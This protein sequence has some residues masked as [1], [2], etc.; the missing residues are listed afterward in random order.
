[1]LTGIMTFI[2]VFRVAPAAKS[3]STET[4]SRIVSNWSYVVSVERI[5]KT[6]NAPV[7]AVELFARFSTV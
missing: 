6:S 1:M 5:K 3:A 4:S 2:L 7:V